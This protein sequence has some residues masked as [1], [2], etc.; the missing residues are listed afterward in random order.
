MEEGTARVRYGGYLVSM[1]AV[2]N[3]A[4]RAREILATLGIVEHPRVLAPDTDGCVDSID[5][6]TGEAIA[7]IRL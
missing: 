1:K 4:I 3:S 2:S 6:A 5:P 7:A